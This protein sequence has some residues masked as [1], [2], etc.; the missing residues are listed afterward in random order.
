MISSF[1]FDIKI[2]FQTSSAEFPHHHFGKYVMERQSLIQSIA[3]ELIEKNE[4]SLSYDSHYF[5]GLPGSGKTCIAHLLAKKLVENGMDVY[6][7]LDSEILNSLDYLEVNSWINS[8]NKNTVIIVD[9]VQKNQNSAKWTCFLKTSNC[10]LIVVGF[11]VPILYGD[12][13]AFS[14]KHSPVELLYKEQSED[15][16][17]LVHL[18]MKQRRTLTEAQVRAVCETICEYVNGQ[19][20]PLLKF[21]EH[22][23]LSICDLGFGISRYDCYEMCTVLM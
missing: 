21:S 9:E 6:F 12:S 17:E 7:F 23:L 14:I 5:R 10:Y 1:K 19:A 2:N 3:S 20:Y 13:P 18:F 15:M 4:N 8:L 11:G 22:F 16:N